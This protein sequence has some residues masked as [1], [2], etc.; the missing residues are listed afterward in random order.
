MTEQPTTWLTMLIRILAVLLVGSLG[1][2]ALLVAVQYG[3]LDDRW[4]GTDK[5][6]PPLLVLVAYSTLALIGAGICGRGGKAKL[7]IPAMLASAV[8]AGWWGILILFESAMSWD[9][10]SIVSRLAFTCTLVCVMLLY[11]EGTGVL[12]A[13]V[14]GVRTLRGIIR[15]IAWSFGLLIVLTMWVPE[16][17]EDLVMAANAEVAAGLIMVA[18]AFIT[19]LGPAIIKAAATVHKRK[20]IAGHGSLVSKLMLDLGCPQCAKPM[21]AAPGPARC[22]ACGF[23]MVI[24]IEE[25]R[26]GCGY[27]I[28]EHTSE[29][30]PECGDLIDPDLWWRTVDPPDTPPTVPLDPAL[31]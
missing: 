20:D 25:P 2:M 16:I 26:C 1:I 4:Y 6:Y 3:I 8:A 24:E 17:V 10:E 12:E 11:H 15:G 23:V 5:I 30:C 27:I 29:R 9:M 13:G 18:C 22:R 14:D 31:D 19:L 7:M 21:T 28:Y